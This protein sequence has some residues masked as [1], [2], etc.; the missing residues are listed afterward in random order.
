ME[1]LQLS[2]TLNVFLS[3][4]TCG[5]NRS[6]LGSQGQLTAKLGPEAVQPTPPLKNFLFT[7]QVSHRESKMTSQ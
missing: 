4:P 7:I 1:S 5:P 6:S 3:S 2:E